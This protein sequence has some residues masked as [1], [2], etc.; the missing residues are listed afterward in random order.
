[1]SKT[2]D[3]FTFFLIVSIIILITGCYTS[4]KNVTFTK[5]AGQIPPEFNGYND[6]LLVIRHPGSG[7]Y[8]RCLKKNFLAYYTGKYK[9]I[10]PDQIPDH[11]PM[12]KYRFV[13]DRNLNYT[14]RSSDFVRE[15]SL[16]SVSFP[17]T[18][19]Y[20]TGIVLLVTDRTTGKDYIG[21]SSGFYSKYM[22]A[23]I[24]ALDAERLK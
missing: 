3:H 2:H 22:I 14:T 15:T 13:F 17:N 23:Y 7:D 20:S 19:T 24:K 16:G 4:V 10:T 18:A 8:N 21:G 1:M 6:T 11:Y 12:S 5:E 9:I